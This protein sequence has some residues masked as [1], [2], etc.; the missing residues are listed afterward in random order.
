MATCRY[1]NAKS[2]F[3]NHGLR[4]CPLRNDTYHIGPAYSNGA[5]SSEY[6]ISR[7]SYLRNCG[8]DRGS[9][10]V[11]SVIKRPYTSSRCCVSP[12]DQRVCRRQWRVRCIAQLRIG[13]LYL[14]SILSQSTVDCR[15]LLGGWRVSAE[16]FHVPGLL[17]ICSASPRRTS[18]MFC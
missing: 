5:V 12:P 18:A 17:S 16:R 7:R 6:T 15:V 4:F 13:E 9:T 2:C 10:F 3:Y 1:N 14:T 8:S 11:R